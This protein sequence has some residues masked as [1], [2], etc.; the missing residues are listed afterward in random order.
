MVTPASSFS[1]LGAVRLALGLTVAMGC[2]APATDAERTERI[3]DPAV[4]QATFDR[5][6]Q[7][8]L[9]LAAMHLQPCEH[10]A[11]IGAGTGLLTVHLARAVTACGRVVA[12]D[13]NPRVLALMQSR[14]DAAGVAAWTSPR[15]VPADDPGLGE[16]T[17][18]AILLSE[19]DNYLPDAPRWLRLATERLSAR[20]RLII[21]NRVQRRAA[22]LAAAAT[23]GLHLVSESSPTPSH[24]IA[25]FD[26]GAPR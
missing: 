14:L 16:E 6:R 1:G 24:F 7:P 2:S 26:R 3:A 12:T 17:F 20:G 4:E 23:A 25:V 19:V 18:D 13:V 11:D 8:A 5:D 10:V 9:L 21:T 22:A 15:Q